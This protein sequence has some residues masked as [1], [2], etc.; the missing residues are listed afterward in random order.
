MWAAIFDSNSREASKETRHDLHAGSHET[1]KERRSCLIQQIQ[2]GEEKWILNYPFCVAIV[3][4]ARAV[5]HP[6]G[7]ALPSLPRPISDLSLGC[8]TQVA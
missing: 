3:D 8:S 1:L 2:D 7:H 5:W 6:M 4:A